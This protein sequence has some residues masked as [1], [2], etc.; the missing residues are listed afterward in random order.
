MKDFFQC[1]PRVRDLI[2]DDLYW[3]FRLKYPFSGERQFIKQPELESNSLKEQPAV[4]AHVLCSP[5]WELANWLECCWPTGVLS[6]R[7]VLLVANMGYWSINHTPVGSVP[8]TQ[9]LVV[10]SPLLEVRR[11]LSL[12]R[13]WA[14]SGSAL[15]FGSPPWCSYT[16]ETLTWRRQSLS[17]CVALGAYGGH[18]LVLSRN[19][20][21]PFRPKASKKWCFKEHGYV[22]EQESCRSIPKYS[23]SMGV[24]NLLRLVPSNRDGTSFSTTR[25]GAWEAPLGL[26]CPEA[27]KE[28]SLRDKQPVRIPFGQQLVRTW[29]RQRGEQQRGRRR[30]HFH[31]SGG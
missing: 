26:G 8:M 11:T 2:S 20:P 31:W 6:V 18:N 5:T 12:L 13:G 27:L 15:G 24:S 16:W 1:C 7:T 14:G 28:G 10:W 30:R 29:A 19:P 25:W 9:F 21:C 3:F 4:L 17:Y 23:L 22:C